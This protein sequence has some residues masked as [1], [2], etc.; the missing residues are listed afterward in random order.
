MTQTTIPYWFVLMVMGLLTFFLVRF[1]YMVDEIRKDVKSML[2]SEAENALAIEGL[3]EKIKEIKDSMK[4]QQEK[5]NDLDREI[6]R[7]KKT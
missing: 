4:D 7:M 5:L 1:Y 6:G 2:V 3:K